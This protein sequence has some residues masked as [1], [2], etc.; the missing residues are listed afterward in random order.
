[1]GQ[2]ISWRDETMI[3]FQKCKWRVF[4]HFIKPARRHL[5][6]SPTIKFRWYGTG[7]EVSYD[8]VQHSPSCVWV[9]AVD[10]A[11]SYSDAVVPVGP[12]DTSDGEIHTAK[13]YVAGG[14]WTQE[15]NS[16]IMLDNTSSTSPTIKPMWYE[17]DEEVSY[18][19]VQ[20]RSTYIQHST[21]RRKRKR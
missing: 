10:A 5:S 8:I 4:R 17:R 1:V 16:D 19:I 7:E 21:I 11:C 6:L 15:L 18:A 2:P 20:Q 3:F 9:V 14:N 12:V 13:S